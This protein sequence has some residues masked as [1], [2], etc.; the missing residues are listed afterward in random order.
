MA[1]RG[2]RF[3][4][5]EDTDVVQPQKTTREQ[6]LPQHILT[7]NPPGEIE[8]QL[9]KG[10]SQ[11]ETVLLTSRPRHLVHAPTGPGMDRRIHV[12]VIILVSRYLPV[13]VH[14]PLPQEQLKLILR[15]LR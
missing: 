15:E 11:E 13:G 10:S 6:M 3:G 7:G 8:Q 1:S 5:V 14:V 2:Q 4:A 9:L 12:A